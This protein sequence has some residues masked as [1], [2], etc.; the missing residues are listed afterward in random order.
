MP[1][2]RSWVKKVIV[3]D[4]EAYGGLVNVKL[5]MNREVTWLV[6]L[7]RLPMSNLVDDPLATL[8][9]VVCWLDVT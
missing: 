8:T 5:A 3:L 1:D 2:I 9:W 7:V 4:S 6:E